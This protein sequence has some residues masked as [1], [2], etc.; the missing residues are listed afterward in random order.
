MLTPA[1][2]GFRLVGVLLLSVIATFLWFLF[3][4]TLWMQEDLLLYPAHWVHRTP[5]IPLHHHPG[6]L[7]HISLHP[8]SG[9]C[10]LTLHPNLQ[11]RVG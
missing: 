11:H 4:R 3:C 5:R 6:A 9:L 10:V 2:L 1:S 7:G 8:P